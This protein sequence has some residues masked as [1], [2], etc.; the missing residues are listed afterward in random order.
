MDLLHLALALLI[1]AQQPNVPIELRNTAIN[2]ANSAIALSMQNQS[3]PVKLA[4]KTL[5]VVGESAGKPVY[6]G[7]SKFV[8][9]SDGC[10]Y[11]VIGGKVTKY[12][13]WCPK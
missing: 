9:G 11:P 3:L 5:P 10:Q 2:V 12:K 1:A 6:Q 8:V 7:T 13:V 4:E